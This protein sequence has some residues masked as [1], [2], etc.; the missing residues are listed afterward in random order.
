MMFPSELKEFVGR[1]MV[2]LRVD[3]VELMSR[4]RTGNVALCRQISMWFAYEKLNLN[5]D[6]IG[7]MF[8]RDHTTAMYAK[9]QIN[10]LIDVDLP[11]REIIEKAGVE[12]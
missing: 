6:K 11:T 3:D 7:Q 2:I 8:N 4:K 12:L 10:G 1:L 5:Y 9:N